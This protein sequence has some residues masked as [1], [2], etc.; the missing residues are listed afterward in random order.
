VRKTSLFAVFLTVFI[1]LLGFGMV[2]PLLPR[3]AKEHHASYFVATLLVAVYSFMQFLFAPMWGRISD[4][5]GRRPVL[6]WTLAGNAASYALFAVAQ[7]LP[8]LFIARAMSGF[9]AANISTAQAYMADI[10]TP[11]RRTRAMGLIGMAFGLGFVL[12]PAFGIAL[13]HYATWAPGAG[14]AAL[15]AIACGLAVFRLA[16][17]L[18][19]ELR[20]LAQRRVAHPILAL[21]LALRNPSLAGVL[22]LFFFLVFGFANLEAVLSLFIGDRYGTGS[23]GVSLTEEEIRIKVGWVFVYI[24]VC[25]TF[26]QGFLV[27]RVAKRWGEVRILRIAPWILVVG[28]QAYWLA[29]SMTWFLV[30]VPL[31]ALGFGMSN[32]TVASLISQRTPADVQGQTLGLN[33]SLGALARAV[34][35]GLAGLLYDLYDERIP[36]IVGGAVVVVGIGLSARALALPTVTPSAAVPPPAE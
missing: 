15:S 22:A 28:M 18:A 12:G 25:I 2:V 6:A 35:P 36:F 20:G 3:Y 21:G 5:R 30:A 1:D 17:S 16:E 8:T 24:G 10:T 4:R 31:V 34:A 11:E 33:Q 9:F 23:G 7:N 14:A 19:P 26:V 27:G 29:P 32:P 13:N